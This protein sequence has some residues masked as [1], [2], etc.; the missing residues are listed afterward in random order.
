MSIGKGYALSNLSPLELARE[1]KIEEPLTKSYDHL[2]FSFYM[3]SKSSYRGHKIVS[4]RL[5]K[6]VTNDKHLCSE[7]FCL[8]VLSVVLLIISFNTEIFKIK[9]DVRMKKQES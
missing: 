4:G 6:R 1:L 3:N 9:S 5:K 7:F 2:R 8:I